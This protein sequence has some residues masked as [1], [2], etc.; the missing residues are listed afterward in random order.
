[1]SAPEMRIKKI[2][3]KPQKLFFNASDARQRDKLTA[4]SRGG[5]C[6]RLHVDSV[7]LRNSG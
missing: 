1:M 3:K 5:R 7:I 4:E 2:E 6:K